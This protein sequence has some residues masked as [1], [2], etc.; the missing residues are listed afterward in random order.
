M[1]VMSSICVHP[2]IDIHSDVLVSSIRTNINHFFY[3]QFF[4]VRLVLVIENLRLL[5]FFAIEL[6][7]KYFLIIVWKA[8]GCFSC[9]INNGSISTIDL[10]VENILISTQIFWAMLEKFDH[11]KFGC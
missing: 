5:T 11:Q 2:H 8:F 4:L 1:D 7:D 3:D 9:L 6:G 10:A